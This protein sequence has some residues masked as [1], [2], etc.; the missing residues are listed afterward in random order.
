MENFLGLRRRQWNKAVCLL[1]FQKRSDFSPWFGPGIFFVVSC[2]VA[3]KFSKK[4]RW[5][6]V[7]GNE[8][9]CNYKWK[10]KTERIYNGNIILEL[11]FWHISL[12][13]GSVV[14]EPHRKISF[15][16]KKRV[17]KQR[18]SKEWHS[19]AELQA[20][21]EHKFF[22]PCY[23]W[24]WVSRSPKSIYIIRKRR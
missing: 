14:W 7:R 20:L 13:L 22:F 17:S 23:Q 18:L 12:T 21:V 19:L 16:P 2:A 8:W 10:A 9:N 24:K 4:S 15:W 6:R 3:C 5:K 1:D 11:G